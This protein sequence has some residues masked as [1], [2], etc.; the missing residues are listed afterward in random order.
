[1]TERKILTERKIVGSNKNGFIIGNERAVCFQ[2]IPLY[3]V[4]QNTFHEQE[5]R[6]E[7]GGSIR[8]NPIGLTFEKEYVFLKGGRPVLYEQKDI[9]KEIMPEK[10]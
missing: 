2:D 5:N 8:Y 10:E 3:G 1:M 7:L 6:A 9:A 4:C